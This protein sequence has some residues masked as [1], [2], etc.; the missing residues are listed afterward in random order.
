M[1]YRFFLISFL[2]IPFKN[3]KIEQSDLDFNDALNN[4]VTSL[5][6]IG[7]LLPKILKNNEKC[8]TD[9]DCPL[10]MKCCEVGLIKYC[11]SPNNYIK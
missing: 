1:I 8:K 10:I 11:C 2:T 5:G 9:D 7:Y 4:I 3:L 6:A